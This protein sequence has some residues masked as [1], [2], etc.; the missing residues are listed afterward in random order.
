MHI[1]LQ[2]RYVKQRVHAGVCAVDPSMIIYRQHSTLRSIRELW[3]SVSLADADVT[4]VFDSFGVPIN[5]Y[6]NVVE[7]LTTRSASVQTTNV[8]LQDPRTGV[9]GDH[10]VA[11]CLAASRSLT[12]SEFVDYW[13]YWPDRDKII[14]LRVDGWMRY[15][16]GK[17]L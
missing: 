14:C 10:G 5:L 16:R 8:T 3:L 4:I 7:A 15:L 2:R 17:M 13:K 9:C 12:L 1:H 11:F 6:S